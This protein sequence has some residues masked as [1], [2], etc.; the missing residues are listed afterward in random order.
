[1]P[2]IS[3]WVVLYYKHQNVFHLGKWATMVDGVWNHKWD[4]QMCVLECDNVDFWDCMYIP[5]KKTE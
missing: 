2:G 4:F 3:M 5:G 1:M